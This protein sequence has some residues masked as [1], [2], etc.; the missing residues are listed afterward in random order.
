M[1]GGIE[2]AGLGLRKRVR[3]GGGWYSVIVTLDESGATIVEAIPDEPEP[4]HKTRFA[5]ARI[6]ACV[7]AAI[8]G[9]L[10]HAA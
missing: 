6:C 4:S 9:E 8:E 5:R 2:A 1:S 7:T 3:I 10:S